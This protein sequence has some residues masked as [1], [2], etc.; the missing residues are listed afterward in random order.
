M[1][2]DG[3]A[4]VA[5]AVRA[6][7]MA[8][9]PRRT[10]MGVAAAVAGVF[11]HPAMARAKPENAAA[12]QASARTEHAEGEASQE[13]LL[14]ALRSARRSQ[15]QRKKQ[16]RRARQADRTQESQE[17]AEAADVPSADGRGLVPATPVAERAMVQPAREQYTMA[18]GP[19]NMSDAP[20]NQDQAMM[21]AESSSKRKVRLLENTCAHDAVSDGTGEAASSVHTRESALPPDYP[22]AAA[23]SVPQHQRRRQQRSRSK[24]SGGKS[25]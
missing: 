9:A 14:T 6:A 8:H 5:A 25:R 11:A 21:L 24:R 17:E 15:R 16:R 19:G 20:V 2:A 1:V 13:D 4:F 3:P 22:Q 23:P 7:C 18:G 10:V 12:A